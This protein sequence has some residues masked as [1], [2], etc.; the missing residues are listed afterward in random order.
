MHQLENCAQDSGGGNCYKKVLNDRGEILTESCFGH[1]E[2]KKGTVLS[3]L[4][5]FPVTSLNHQ[6]VDTQNQRHSS[7]LPLVQAYLGGVLMKYEIVILPALGS[8]LRNQRN[9]EMRSQKTGP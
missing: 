5:H 9:K 1:Q 6:N 4:C 7:S 3:S 2:Y 8:V